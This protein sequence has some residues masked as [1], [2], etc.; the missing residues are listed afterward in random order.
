MLSNKAQIELLKTRRERLLF[1]RYLLNRCDSV[2]YN[3]RN[4]SLPIS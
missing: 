1:L 2:M 3:L 4:V